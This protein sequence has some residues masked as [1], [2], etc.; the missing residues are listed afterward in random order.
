M[1]ERRITAMGIVAVALASLLGSGCLVKE[2]THTWY[3]DEDGAVEWVVQ[4]KDVRSDAKTV[5]DRRIEEAAYWLSVQQERHPVL[6]GFRELGGSNLRIAILRPSVPYSLQTEARFTGLDLLGQRIIAS[7]GGMGSSMVARDGTT[8]T[9]TFTM[10][11]PSGPGGTGDPTDAIT[12]LLSNLEDLR[13]VLVQGFF[14]SAA[15]FEISK[16][17]RVA[18]FQTEPSSGRETEPHSPLFTLKLVWKSAP[19]Q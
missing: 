9:W 7:I 10:R 12:D 4:E 13:I 6:Q 14:E 11:D 3:L 2:I 16:D 19:A 1:A 8:W 18:R 17:G 15:G 5:E